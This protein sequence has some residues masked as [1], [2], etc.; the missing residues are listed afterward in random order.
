MKKLE[1]YA[2]NP[3]GNIGFGRDL[4]VVFFSDMTDRLKQAVA[5]GAPFADL[6]A[7]TSEKFTN[8]QLSHSSTVTAKTQL[9]SQTLTVDQ[10]IDVFKVKIL[11]SEALVLTKF[12]KPTPEYL[13]FF[14]NG[15]TAYNNVN[16][17]NIDTMMDQAILAFTLHQ[18]VLGSEILKEFQD[19]K[20]QYDAARSD[21]QRQKQNK[22]GSIGSWDDNLE[23]MKDQAFD[24]L[25]VIARNY[26]GQPEKIK[27]Y[28][29]TS[30]ITPDVHP[31]PEEVKSA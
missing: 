7:P 28:F 24:N 29:D 4:T 20:D 14:P 27:M 17:G 10:I 18:D 5:N 30:I 23:I 31:E 3:F 13:K 2:E 9:K 16:K 12:K 8:L 1:S 6:L 19:L 11:D 15:R 22:G 21:Q 26:K 25:L